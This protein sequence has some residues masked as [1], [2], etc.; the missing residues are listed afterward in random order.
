MSVAATMRDQHDGR[1]RST[2]QLL[3][4]G[5]VT[6][7]TATSVETGRFAARRATATVAVRRT[8]TLGAAALRRSRAEAACTGR[9]ATHR[10]TAADE[11]MRRRFLR[12]RSVPSLDK[13]AKLKRLALRRKCGA[14]AVRTSGRPESEQNKNKTRSCSAS[15]VLAHSGLARVVRAANRYDA[16]GAA[17]RCDRESQRCSAR[18]S[19]DEKL[20][21]RGGRH[22]FCGSD[23]SL[24][25]SRSGCTRDGAGI[26]DCR[27][28]RWNCWNARVGMLSVGGG[29]SELGGKAGA[30]DR[31]CMVDRGT[32][33]ARSPLYG[34]AKVSSGL[35]QSEIVGDVGP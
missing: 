27:L 16:L 12:Q 31:P 26:P 35:V 11:A 8:W 19:A 18:C 17:Q 28:F 22:C 23:W 30:E 6:V 4:S 25:V 1:S 33:L 10:A 29:Y 20:D 15:R 3:P 14:A 13:V 2:A 32:R 5:L 7:P 34:E 24:S 9:A 21:L